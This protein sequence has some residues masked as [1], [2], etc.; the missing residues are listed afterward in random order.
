MRIDLY[1]LEGTFWDYSKQSYN[2]VGKF[3]YSAYQSTKTGVINTLNNPRFQGSMQAVGGLAEAGAGR[4]LTLGSRGILGFIGAPIMAHGMN[5]VFSGTSQDT[6]TSQLLQKTGMSSNVA[7]MVDNGISILGSF[8]GVA[9]FRSAGQATF[10]VPANWNQNTQVLGSVSKNNGWVLPENGG[11]GLINNRWYTEHALERMAP[12]TPQVMAKLEARFFER[13]KVVKPKLNT[14][15]FLK[16]CRENS[17]NPRGVPP[18]VVEAEIA[19]PGSSGVRVFL[20]EK[21]DVKTVI[22]E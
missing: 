4:L 19:N 7:G 9:A 16:W 14:Q 6:I 1:G 21:G 18:S 22:P 3:S 15:E 17:P 5:R 8:G 10:R 13:A 11:G 20:N 2:N 12:N